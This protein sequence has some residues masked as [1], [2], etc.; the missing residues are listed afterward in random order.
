M[1]PA[2]QF[3]SP[4]FGLNECRVSGRGPGGDPPLPI[5]PSEPKQNTQIRRQQDSKRRALHRHLDVARIHKSP[6]PVE[7]SQPAQEIEPMSWFQN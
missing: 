4:L 1:L 2:G 6:T 7:N 3:E 5:R